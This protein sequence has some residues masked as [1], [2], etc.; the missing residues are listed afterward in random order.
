MSFNLYQ[1]KISTIFLI[2]SNLSNI[3]IIEQ[4]LI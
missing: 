3:E 4:A 1:V 2:I